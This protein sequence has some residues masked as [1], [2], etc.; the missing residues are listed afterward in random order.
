[1]SVSVSV[2]LVALRLATVVR[3]SVI[4][5]A[6][7]RGAGHATV[8]VRV[9]RGVGGVHGWFLELHLDGVVGGGG[10]EFGSEDV[11][12]DDDTGG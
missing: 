2:I 6:V 7:V 4:V 10:G 9:R 3:V 12:V 5:L 8:G 1:M 11:L